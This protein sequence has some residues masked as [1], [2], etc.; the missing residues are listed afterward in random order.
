MDRS[1]GDELR[2]GDVQS[3]RGPTRSRAPGGEGS[4][5]GARSPPR[6]DLCRARR[7]RG[8]RPRAR[9]R[10]ASGGSTTRVVVNEAAPATTQGTAARQITVGA[11][12]RSRRGTF[13]PARIFARALARRRHDLHLHGGPGGRRAPGFVVDR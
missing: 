4:A 3:R 12:G 13:S 9:S 8:A 5:V 1:P 2:L 6:P 11:A 7:G 10:S